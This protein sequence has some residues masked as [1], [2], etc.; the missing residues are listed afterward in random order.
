MDPQLTT[1]SRT[2]PSRLT[3]V[4]TWRFVVGFALVAAA[5]ALI[6]Y[7]IFSSA[8]KSENKLA[9]GL[10]LFF[11]SGPLLYPSMLREGETVSTMRAVVYMLGVVFSVT[12]FRLAWRAESFAELAP[13]PWWTAIITAALG[14]KAIQSFAEPSA[15]AERVSPPGPGAGSGVDTPP[16]VPA[17]VPPSP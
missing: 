11:M 10:L 4:E 14:G 16:P 9:A 3:T 5:F 17:R 13:N 7:G 8:A 6:A 1:P 15:P 12:T 2:P